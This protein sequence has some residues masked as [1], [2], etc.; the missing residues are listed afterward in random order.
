MARA[1]LKKGGLVH[2]IIIKQSSDAEKAHKHTACNDMRRF[3]LLSCRVKYTP[4]PVTCE[5]CLLTA[6]SVAGVGEENETETP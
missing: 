1:R 6:A 3:S 2:E 4:D 5:G